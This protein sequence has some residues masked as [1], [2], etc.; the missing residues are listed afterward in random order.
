MQV[1]VEF[2]DAPELGPVTAHGRDAWALLELYRAGDAGCTPITPSRP[3]LV[4]LRAQ[5][6]QARAANR[7]CLRA[8]QRPVCRPSRPLCAAVQNSKLSPKIAERSQHER[9]TADRCHSASMVVGR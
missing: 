4:C 5:A 8:A 9:A 7:D 1:T 6:S 3:A 2:L